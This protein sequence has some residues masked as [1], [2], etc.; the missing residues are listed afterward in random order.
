MVGTESYEAELPMVVAA[1]LQRLRQRRGLSAA[2]TARLAGL[3]Q[4]TLTEIENGE[5]FPRIDVIWKLA[6]VLGV[7]F[8]TILGEG[9][10]SRTKV[11]RRAQ[12][13]VLMSSRGQ[14]T[15]RVLF[16]LD[17]EARAEFYELRLAPGAIE[18]A[19]GH[20]PGTTENLVVVKGT[21]VI[22]VDGSAHVL[23]EGDALFF[24]ADVDHSYQNGGGDG[25][26]LHLVMA[27]TLDAP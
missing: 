24:H 3:A 18:R 12:A 20:A 21:A 10:G 26:V 4:Q 7:P 23:N 9:L 15:S 14:L 22:E 17:G 5:V 1:N 2:E 25:L 27:Y 8:G 6:G 11:M 16:P 19:A 13:D